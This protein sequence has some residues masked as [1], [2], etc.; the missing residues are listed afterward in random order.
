MTESDEIKCAYSDEYDCNNK[1]RIGEEK[2]PAIDGKNYCK[3][4]WKQLTAEAESGEQG[5]EELTE[6]AEDVT[7]ETVTLPEATEADQTNTAA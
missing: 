7:N 3:I 4:H 1:A 6:P 5:E 2:Y